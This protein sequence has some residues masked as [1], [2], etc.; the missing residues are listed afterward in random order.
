MFIG[1]YGPALAGKSAAKAVPLWALFVAVQ[2]LDYLWGLFIV[3]G[4]ERMRIEPGFT[5]MSPLDL[6]DMPWTHS[7]LMAGVWSLILGAGW[8]AMTKSQ[9][10]LGGLVMGLAVLSHWFLDLLM[11]VPDLPLWPDGPK[12]GFGAWRNEWLT[13]VLEF[14]VLAL[15]CAFYLGAT[16]PKGAMGRVGPVLLALIMLGVYWFSLTGPLPSR[17]NEAGL[18][19]IFAYTLMALLAW[20]LCDRTR[21]AK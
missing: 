4:V 17:P 8:A 14:G 11:H 21:A 6:Y 13:L 19:A 5:T 2:F 10:A 18:M 3:L 1:H 15:G 16:K 20:L 12:V 9:K 7:L